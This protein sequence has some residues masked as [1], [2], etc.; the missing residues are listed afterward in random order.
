M[1]INSVKKKIL[2]G[3]FRWFPIKS[4]TVV[5]KSFNGQYNDNPKYISEKLHEKCSNVEIV[6]VISDK[7]IGDD[8]PDYVKKVDIKSLKCDKICATAQV[9][10]DNMSGMQ[11]I[12][13]KKY[14]KLFDYFIKRRGQYNIS[15]WHGTPLKKIGCD[16][17]SDEIELYQ[18][19][20]RYITAGN[21]Y[22]YDIFK[23]S[24]NGI[25]I[26]L[27]GTARND[28]FINNNI[29]INELKK[30]LELPI[31]KKVILFAPTFRDSVENSGIVQIKGF[32]INK[33]FA[34]LKQ[35]FGGE[36]IMVLRLHHT[37]L[38]KLK[39]MSNEL[40][41]NNIIFD[42]NMH[43]DMAEYLLC[44]DVLLTDYSSCMFD[45]MYTKRPCFL[46][47]NDKE[48][49]VN[50]E[51]GTYMDIGD[52]PYDFAE[53]LDSL[54]ENISNYN[55]L[56]SRIAIEKFLDKIGNVE[57]GYASERVV[58]DILSFTTRKE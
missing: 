50:D 33:I 25:D 19:S 48:K 40:I 53:D 56:E 51:R 21:K 29:K 1:L 43:D 49:Y 9:L 36:W 17:K 12:R 52:L 57:D 10:V 45:F 3:I 35:K 16:I 4:N 54:Y 18:S 30:K 46:Y 22:S 26:K 28:V 58:N 32:D 38:K 13:G 11:G 20:S 7:S 55:E 6:W 2:F 24:F 41:D 39:N 44:S 8:F 34:E 42:G 37:V 5:F 47:A 15:T 31:D 23:H 27:Y 14:I